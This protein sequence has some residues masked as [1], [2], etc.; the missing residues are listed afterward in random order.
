[1]ALATPVPVLTVSDGK[2][3]CV[4]PLDD[5]EAMRYSYRQ[6]IY[7]VPVWEEFKRDGDR[8]ELLRVRSTDIRS[9]EYFRWDDAIVQ[10]SD[11]WWASA[12][13]PGESGELVIR[14][15]PLGQQRIVT[16][17]WTCDMLARFGESVVAVR[18]DRRPLGL[19]IL[20]AR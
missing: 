16:A 20:A 14:I 3:E 18:A 17:R 9:I 8:L 11:G 10:E 12:A 7:D 4:G 19:T 1:M 2:A 5:G 15:A 6:S 13:P